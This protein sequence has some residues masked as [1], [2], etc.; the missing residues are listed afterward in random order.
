[1]EEA[2]SVCGTTF[3]TTRTPLAYSKKLICRQNSAERNPPIIGATQNR[4][5]G[6]FSVYCVFSV[7]CCVFLN[8]HVVPFSAVR[9]VPRTQRHHYDGPAGHQQVGRI[10][11]SAV[12]VP[13]MQ[14]PTSVPRYFSETKEEQSC[15]P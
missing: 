3:S 15:E 7:T 12:Q 11:E 14:L 10:S 5:D 8:A 1:V 13:F 9:N 2:R 4:Q 6:F